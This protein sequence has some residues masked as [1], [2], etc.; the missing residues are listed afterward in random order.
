MIEDRILDALAIEMPPF[1]LTG[2]KPKEDLQP[3][4]WEMGF[5][6]KRIR[7]DTLWERLTKSYAPGTREFEI[8]VENYFR[9]IW[10][11]KYDQRITTFNKSV[12]AQMQ[13]A[14]KGAGEL[15]FLHH[16]PGWYPE[17]HIAITP[18]SW[19]GVRLNRMA[20]DGFRVLIR[21]ELQREY[22][23]TF[24]RLLQKCEQLWDSLYFKHTAELRDRTRHIIAMKQSYFR[25][26]ARKYFLVQAGFSM[27]ITAILIP[28]MKILVH[29]HVHALGASGMATLRIHAPK[30][31]MTL[32]A[33]Y[34]SYMLF[35]MRLKNV[36][37]IGSHI[38]YIILRLK[39]IWYHLRHGDP[40]THGIIAT[41]PTVKTTLGMLLTTG[42][43]GVFVGLLAVV[44]FGQRV[45]A[46]QISSE[47]HQEYLEWLKTFEAMKYK[48]ELATAA[49]NMQ[50]AEILIENAGQAFSS[51]SLAGL[52]EERAGFSTLIMQ[53]LDEAQ[54][55]VRGISVSMGDEHLAPI[56]QELLAQLK[57]L[58]GKTQPLGGAALPEMAIEEYIDPWRILMILEPE[59]AQLDPEGT[60]DIKEVLMKAMEAKRPELEIYAQQVAREIQNVGEI[61]PEEFPSLEAAVEAGEIFRGL[62][63]AEDV[64]KE[65]YSA[66]LS[67]LRGA[68]TNA[69]PETLTDIGELEGM[70]LEVL[71][72]IEEWEKEGFE[73]TATRL[74]EEA[75]SR[76]MPYLPLDW[77]AEEKNG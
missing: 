38:K 50:Q 45:E 73:P 27:A 69:D 66:I 25:P 42:A 65:R 49:A 48:E 5:E 64:S 17:G 29:A 13:M 2:A 75:M 77:I 63:E 18:V 7:R 32:E 30:A 28:Y 60:A 8:G 31:A 56:R 9:Q 58:K 71:G 23:A 21:N 43:V 39:W 22:A 67:Q 34:D 33:Y 1:L 62:L 70:V 3:P 10:Y 57:K 61:M 16:I 40:A 72:N 41:L 12:E 47:E 55:L 35:R 24:S 14:T 74:P 59:I 46:P 68:K 54:E 76:A 51:L 19:L 44:F 20:Q 15:A 26:F 4:G 37:A 36:L 6:G 52:E 11:P 53:N